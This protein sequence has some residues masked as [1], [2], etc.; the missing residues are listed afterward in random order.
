MRIPDRS[1]LCVLHMNHMPST[2]CALYLN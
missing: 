2:V 1:Q